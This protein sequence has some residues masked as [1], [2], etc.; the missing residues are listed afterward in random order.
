MGVGTKAFQWVATHER[1]DDLGG[2]GQSPG[3][4]PSVEAHS[5][6]EEITGPF[7]RLWICLATEYRLPDDDANPNQQRLAA[8]QSSTSLCFTQFRLIHGHSGGLNARPNAS[9][10]SSYHE[11]CNGMCRRLQRSSDLAVKLILEVIWE[12]SI[13]Q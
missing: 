12:E 2:D 7:Q 8:N 13:S 4:L 11:L 3:D 9:N 10:K 5:I 6:V 1:E